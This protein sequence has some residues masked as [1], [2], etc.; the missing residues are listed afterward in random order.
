MLTAA[1]ELGGSHAS[2]GLVATSGSAPA[3]HNHQHLAMDTRVDLPT[4]LDN[5]DRACE[6]LIAPGRPWVVAIPGPFDYENAIGGRHVDGKFRALDGVD[7][8]ALLTERWQAGSMSFCNDADAFGAG[9]WD[10]YGRPHRLFALTLGSGIGAAFIADGRPVTEGVP[11]DLYRE[12]WTDGR[13][14]EDHFGPQSL[15]DR[16]NLSTDRY[17]VGSFKELAALARTDAAV[18]ELVVDH[19][20]RFVD[21]LNTWWQDFD[22][23]TVVLGGSVC[24]AW[25]VFGECIRERVAALRG[26]DVAVRAVTDTES[27]ALVGAALLAQP[28]AT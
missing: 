9:V 3:L 2:A 11:E 20:A 18:R 15:V 8:R 6:G 28:R 16:F 1:L 19:M 22:P 10:G 26:P 14:L 5:L 25:D 21:A 7:V 24:H 23:D 27:V 4:L 17:N 13:T 12:P